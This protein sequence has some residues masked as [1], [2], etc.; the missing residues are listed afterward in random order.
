MVGDVEDRSATASPEREA[1]RAIE[2]QRRGAF[3][4]VLI[5]LLLLNLAPLA[6]TVGQPDYNPGA[7]IAS[8]G[9]IALIYFGAVFF[10]RKGWLGLSAHFLTAGIFTVAFACVLFMGGV[11]SLISA[12]FITVILIAALTAGARATT[13]YAALS[14]LACS[15]VFW[16]EYRGLLPEPLHSPSDLDQLAALLTALGASAFLLRRGIRQFELSLFATKESERSNLIALRALEQ[17]QEELLRQR[18]RDDAL[19]DLSEHL[20][21]ISEPDAVAALIRDVIERSFP[22]ALALLVGY[23]R[24]RGRL[25]PLE[26]IASLGHVWLDAQSEERL[27]EFMRSESTSARM[28]LRNEAG[29]PLYLLVHNLPSSTGGSPHGLIAIKTPYSLDEDLEE[30]LEDFTLTVAR[31]LRSSLERF[32]AERGLR[33]SQRIEALGRLSGGIA[34]DFNNLLAVILGASEVLKRRVDSKS[35]ALVHEIIETS[36]KGA[37]LARQ[38]LA[39]A[40]RDAVESTLLDVD[41]VIVDFS[42]IFTRLLGEEIALELRLNAGET[43][44]LA[45][46]AGL[47]QILLNLTVNARDAMPRGGHITIATSI[48]SH[49]DASTGTA[50]EYLALTV[51]DDGIGMNEE[52]RARLFEPFFTTKSSDQGTGLGLPTVYGILN[53]LGGHIEIESAPGK[54]SSFRCLFPIGTKEIRR[55]ERVRIE[56]GGSEESGVGPRTRDESA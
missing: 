14:F 12:S 19:R 11:N 39:F 9:T 47:E 13:I 31:M 8:Y 15:F 45:D 51:S 40:S 55:S 50:T 44:L 32:Q 23:D 17:T 21:T 29:E 24:M 30:G 4:R 38:L 5:G 46:R 49:E 43:Q 7:V 33:E 34:H 1:L 42:R 27:G 2:E 3:K 36:H 56:R 28:E 35:G 54:G 6:A 16:L 22:G 25:A 53:G 52:V 10:F 37:E 26:P 18:L 41:E 20:L 48:E